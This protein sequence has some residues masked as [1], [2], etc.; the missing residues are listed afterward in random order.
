MVLIIKQSGNINGSNTASRN[1]FRSLYYNLNKKL[2]VNNTGS[3][4][5]LINGD[6]I[7]VPL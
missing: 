7:F 6:I 2:S 3:K 4:T 1:F 5:K